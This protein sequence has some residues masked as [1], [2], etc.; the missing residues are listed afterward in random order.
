MDQLSD[1][2]SSRRVFLSLGNAQDTGKEEPV[3][4]LLRTVDA[5]RHEPH[6]PAVSQCLAFLWFLSATT[7]IHPA[8]RDGESFLPAGDTN[9]IDRTQRSVVS[10]EH[11]RPPPPPARLA[12]VTMMNNIFIFCLAVS[13][14]CPDFAPCYTACCCALRFH[15]DVGS[16]RSKLIC[17][18][19]LTLIG[20]FALWL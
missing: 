13:R 4:A 9:P 5:E 12:A 18:D 20:R 14:C 7:A 3:P 17:M 11:P 6:E 15:H 8:R 1:T 19:N 16:L 2:R 10:D